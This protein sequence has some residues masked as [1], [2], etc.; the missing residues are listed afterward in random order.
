[1]LA[2]IR[3]SRQVVVERRE[4]MTPTMTSTSQ[5]SQ[6]NIQRTKQPVLHFK[7]LGVYLAITLLLP[8]PLVLMSWL[9]TFIEDC[10][11]LSSYRKCPAINQCHRN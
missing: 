5:K 2:D 6:V 3:S 9:A 7:T 10:A 11:V 8:S 1:M 4:E